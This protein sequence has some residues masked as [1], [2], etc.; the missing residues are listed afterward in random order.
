MI[1]LTWDWDIQTDEQKIF[2]RFSLRLPTLLP[3]ENGLI[4]LQPTRSKATKH[5]QLV[6][7]GGNFD[8]IPWSRKS[9]I[10]KKRT[11]IM[12][13]VCSSRHYQLSL[14]NRTL[15]PGTKTKER[16][17]ILVLPSRL[18]NSVSLLLSPK[19]W[20]YF[21]A[22]RFSSPIFQGHFWW[23][24]RVRPGISLQFLMN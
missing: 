14:F 3:S 18:G 8:C 15:A 1:R 17:L 19:S 9:L 24:W 21:K 4:A 12:L 7:R 16:Y 13:T 20:S 11:S 10:Q 2:A 6:R 23:A 5:E 22:A